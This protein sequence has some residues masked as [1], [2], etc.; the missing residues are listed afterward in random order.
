[1]K[2]TRQLLFGDL[3]DATA[4]HWSA[5]VVPQSHAVESTALTRASFTYIPSAYIICTEDKACPPQFQR[6]IAEQAKSKLEELQ[7]GH[8]PHLSHLNLLIEKVNSLVHDIPMGK[9]SA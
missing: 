7:S 6:M 4:Q 1:M 2:N 9:E 8:S 3:S 5:Y